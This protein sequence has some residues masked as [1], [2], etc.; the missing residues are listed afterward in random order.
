MLFVLHALLRTITPKVVPE[1][2]RP[3]KA[4]FFQML[5]RLVAF[6]ST[7]VNMFQTE[8]ACLI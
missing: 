6:L 1:Y 5:V 3:C 2:L 7:V 4:L 8:R